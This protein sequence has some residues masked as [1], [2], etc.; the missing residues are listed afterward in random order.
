VAV[1]RDGIAA[2]APARFGLV[3]LD[4]GEDDEAPPAALL[5]R[6]GLH[7]EMAV[8]HGE[9]A[10]DVATAAEVDAARARLP[11]VSA[12]DAQRAAMVEAALRLGAP[13]LRA[14]LFAL[15]T[16]RAL[17]ALEGL[18]APSDH[19]MELALALVLL[20]RA[21]RLPAAP[22]EAEPPPPEPPSDPTTDQRI[23]TS[24][25]E[26]LADRLIEATQ[27]ALP[28]GV[29]ELL[30][31]SALSGK[32]AGRARHGT[33]VRTT[34]HGRA[35]G[36]R[37]G[38]PRRGPRLDLLA[39]VR[40]AAPWQRLRGRPMDDRTAPLRVV[41]D[42]LRVR[43]LVHRVGTTVI[44]V[45]D[46]SGSSALA[47]LNEAKG[48]VELLL[49]DSYVRRDRVAL[50]AF[51]GTRAELVLPPT[52]SLARARRALAGV[53]GGGG[54]PL[55]TALDV[56]RALAV[57][58]RRGGGSPLAVLLTDA[59]AN[60]RRDGTGGRPQAEAEAREAARGLA[61]DGVP[62]L[63]VDTSA[64]PSPFARELAGAM[65]ATYLPLPSG[66]PRRVGDAVRTAIGG[67]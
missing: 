1:E 24:T 48:A 43:R 25:D 13:S 40:T 17:A 60:V 21:T 61:G 8:L 22:P 37:R 63:L 65:N 29:L 32:G 33:E 51:R 42:D 52:R 11:R 55:A 39:T 62:A 20:P 9:C 49:A 6:V 5:E 34:K 23:E 64:R 27:A 46:A 19:E 28:D 67:R 31:R 38:D 59:R 54:T 36:S 12:S 41:R 30:A 66:D 7:V 57:A 50:V 15:A 14:P 44:F 45:V 16:A 18:D 2:S 26:P 53:P 35:V 56:A 4:E 47:R 3:L 58:V 10:F